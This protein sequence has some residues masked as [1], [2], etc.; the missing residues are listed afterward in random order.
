MGLLWLVTLSALALAVPLPTAHSGPAEL[1]KEADRLAWLRAWTA[2]G[3][4]YAQA[5]REFAAA[6][7]Q[8]NA[9]YA[10]IS[11]L[12]SEL[13]RLAVPAASATLAEYLEHP[14]VR[15]DDRL[16][17]R[18][19]VIKGETD[20]DLDPTSAAQAWREAQTIAERLGETAWANRA[21]GELGVTAFLLGDVGSSVI[22]LGDALKVAQ[23][24]GDVSSQVRWLSLFG[25]GYLQ[26]GRP[27][28]ALDFFDRALKVASAVPELQFPLLTHVG[29]SN[30]LIKLGRFEEAD[31]VLTRAGDIADSVGARGYQ[32]QLLAQRASIARERKDPSGAA[33]LFD[34]ALR[35]ARE[36]GA[37]RL[38]AEIALEAGRAQRAQKRDEV[39]DQTLK[40][41]IGAA[42]QMEEK[43]LLSRLLAELADLR[44]T[45]SRYED[46]S[47]LLD[48]ASDV[49][50]GY[51]TSAS[52]PWVVSRLV[53]GMDSVFAAKVRL[54]GLRR[55]SAPRMYAAIEE[56]RGRSL[57]ELLVNSPVSAQQQ[58]SDLREAQRRVA[59]LQ[60]RLLATTEPRP[61]RQLLDQ[62]FAEEERMA[63][64]ATRLF[65]RTRLPGG[66]RAT[67]LSDLQRTL[68]PDELFLEFAL[69]DARS[70]VLVVTNATARVQGLP[71]RAD[72]HALIEN[73]L[74][75]TRGDEAG[76]SEAAALGAALLGPIGELRQRARLVISP[77]G[78]LHG[79]PFELLSTGNQRLLDSHIVSYAPSGAVLTLLRQAGAR[80][81]VGERRVLSVSASLDGGNQIAS[82]KT[83]SRNTYDL[84]PTKLRPLPAAD[85]EV[86]SVGQLFG[87][88]STVLTGTAASEHEIKRM[89]LDNFR[90]LHFAAHGLVSTKYP[91]RSAL[92]LYPGDAE[93]GVLQARE[94]LMLKLAADLVTLS[95]CATGSGDLYGQEGVSSLVKPF[96]AAGARTVVANLWD[97]D[98]T[99][100]L[101]LMREFYRELAEGKDIAAALRAAKRQMIAVHG[102]QATPRLWS[103]LLAYGEGRGVVR[104]LDYTP[105]RQ[106]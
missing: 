8:R 101:A 51:F 91:A 83:V 68:R 27:Q 41:G 3:P 57:L 19:L 10:K 94:I 54:E 70:Y 31:A 102:P 12:R 97:A 37:N 34:H 44:A 90:V 84:D 22:S 28:E 25:Q 33:K 93:D 77:D 7:D 45:A 82:V 55:A 18:C 17:L 21:K 9:L 96:I 106:E 75:V 104:S 60:R 32:A 23:A 46:A 66:T 5:E 105:S 43:L 52:S 98:D 2:A 6:G 49:M 69:L 36:A 48:E 85:D 13:P 67:T 56:A 81:S 14:L 26:L 78:N 64:A 38:V 95:A 89:P 47:A 11:L 65:A 35:M 86:R 4:L 39:A 53:S 24:N 79:I 63:P 99:F 58:S 71:G 62:I 30:V 73:V 42:R 74:R 88:I 76:D 92:L 29:R 80:Q 16:R 1:L 15:S 59:N 20:E 61:R 72:L 100:S 87:P 103:G 50:S 40:A